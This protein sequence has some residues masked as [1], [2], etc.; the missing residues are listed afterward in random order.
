MIGIESLADGGLSMPMSKTVDGKPAAFDKVQLVCL[1][2]EHDR[3][4]NDERNA[5]HSRQA[6]SGTMC[7]L[8]SRVGVYGTGHT[9]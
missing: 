8:T 7:P 9:E 1:V 6:A 3:C 2:E 5:A 4:N